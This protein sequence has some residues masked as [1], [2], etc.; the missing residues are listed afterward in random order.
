MADHHHVNGIEVPS[1][2]ESNC[3]RCRNH[4]LKIILRGH[5][6]YCPYAAC[7]CEKCKFTAEQQRQMRLQNAIRRAEAAERGGIMRRPLRNSIPSMIPVSQTQ[8][9]TPQQIVVTVQNATASTQQNGTTDKKLLFDCS[10]ELLKKFRYPWEMMPICYALA[11]YANGNIEE[12]LQKIDEAQYAVNEQLRLQTL[13]M[14]FGA[15]QQQQQQ[16]NAAV[17]ATTAT[18]ECG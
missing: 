18:R 7:T 6:Q 8:Q 10:S 13:N 4:G 16:Q 5:K 14:Y 9:Q 3:V 17:V 1:R 11:K 15:A 12:I 2:K